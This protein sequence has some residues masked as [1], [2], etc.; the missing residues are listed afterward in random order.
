[1][2]EVLGAGAVARE[3]EQVGAAS[4]GLGTNVKGAT[5]TLGKLKTGLSGLAGAALSPAG[6]TA[7]GTGLVTMAVASVNAFND[8]AL[9]VQ[10]F[11]R[12][13]GGTAEDASRLVA[14][15]DD[16]GISAEAAATGMFQLA[17]RIE[18]GGAT[19]ATFGVHAARASNGTINM[20]ETLLRVGDAYK[21]IADPAQRAA[22]LT[23]AFGKQGVA[24]IPILERSREDI[25]AMFAGAAATGQIFSQEDI[26]KA[27]EFRESMDNLQ[28]AFNEL[29]LRGGEVLV[30][31]LTDIADT[32]VKLTELSDRAQEFLALDP[33]N[34]RMA[35][36]G[37]LGAALDQWKNK[38]LGIEPPANDAAEANKGL[39]KANR[40]VTETVDEQAKA[41]DTVEKALNT[42][43]SADRALAQ[44]QNG[45]VDARDDLNDLLKEGA[46]DT[47]KVASATRSLTSAQRG[48]GSA[49]RDQKE[50][51]EEYNDALAAFQQF[52]GDTNADKLADANNN[53]ADANDSVADAQDRV[54]DA[55][56]ELVKARAGDPDYQEKLADARQ[57]VADA[58]FAVSQNT[59]ATVKAHDAAAIAIASHGEAAKTLL[60][61]YDGLIGRAPQVA[62]AL[63]PLLTLLSL[64]GIG[65]GAPTTPSPAILGPGAPDPGNLS[66]LTTNN[67][68]FNITAPDTIDPMNLA[69]QIVW[70]LNG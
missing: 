69:R 33:D 9:S 4:K 35:A 66:P 23:A 21:E 15:A 67:N 20:S 47:E 10:N 40:E 68:T 19:L 56:A 45:L 59:L 41:L 62:T 57:K 52:G 38:L 2:L 26:A 31:F 44:S 53:L 36:G 58:E 5:G 22:L 28:D 64:A 11:Q 30:P 42:A 48:L 54:V 27:Q 70:N 18:T 55:Q 43:V 46:V 24:L 37:G 63:A 6:L 32:I 65:P 50:A 60:G 16:V 8:L 25:E 14:V 34:S 29:L 3:F 61:Q 51:Q 1:M 49:Q 7:M 39:A 12:V 17:K 13:A